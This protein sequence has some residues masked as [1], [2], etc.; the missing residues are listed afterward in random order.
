MAC[1]VLSTIVQLYCGGPFYWWRLLEYAEKTT[2][3]PQVTD[4]LYHIM[5][6][7]VHLAWA[8]FELNTTTIWSRPRRPAGHWQTLS[9]N[10]VECTVDHHNLNPNPEFLL[11]ITTYIRMLDYDWLIA[12]IFF[13]NSGLALW[14]CRIFT[15]CRCICIRFN[16][17]S[18]Y[19]PF[20][21]FT[22]TLVT[23]FVK[24]Y[25]LCVL[26]N[27]RICRF[28]PSPKRL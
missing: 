1:I 7:Q 24:R 28:Y 22:E 18:W 4:K 10:I 21:P 27:N 26:C 5:L 14:I 23:K 17:F 20:L 12:V 16:F 19:L 8:E 9:Y 25:Q 15:S 6:Y 3:L 13:T 11:I 2:D